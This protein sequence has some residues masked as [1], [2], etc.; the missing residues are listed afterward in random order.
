MDGV[1][2]RRGRAY[3][4]WPVIV[5]LMAG[6]VVGRLVLGAGGGAT[7]QGSNPAATATRTAEVA[8]LERLRRTVAGTV[9]G[10]P[11]AECPPLAASPVATPVAP[12]VA[13][14]PLP[15]DEGWTVTVVA[16][17]DQAPTA[18]QSDLGRTVRVDVV[19]VNALPDAR[20]FPFPDWILIDRDGRRYGFSIV[21]SSNLGSGWARRVEP[22][23]PVEI[24]IAFEVLPDTAGPFVIE[25]D[26][27]PTF[28]VAVELAQRG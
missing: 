27:E 23:L 5:A 24:A 25:S 11:I 22:T 6:V 10:T 20:Q 12:A 14:Q 8:E 15:Y 18:G 19:V 1:E 9:A 26:A 13:G 4:H 28:R 3:R 21:G 2:P 7:A 16:A 17:S